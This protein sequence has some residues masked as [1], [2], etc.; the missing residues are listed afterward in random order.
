MEEIH[1]RR[2][3]MEVAI[4]LLLFLHVSQERSCSFQTYGQ[5]ILI[6]GGLCSFPWDRWQK[7]RSFL[8][9][10]IEAN[11]STSLG[12]WLPS[13]MESGKFKL[14]QRQWEFCTGQQWGWDPLNLTDLKSPMDMTGPITWSWA[15]GKPSWMSQPT[16]QAELEIP[17]HHHSDCLLNCRSW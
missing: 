13:I 12:Q 3:N 6:S 17:L 10:Y 11:L 8:T 4:L 14:Y 1:I 15:D 5:L 9:A 7:S 2:H 16:H